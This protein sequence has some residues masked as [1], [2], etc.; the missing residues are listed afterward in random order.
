MRVFRTLLIGSLAGE[1]ILYFI[2]SRNFLVTLTAL[3]VGCFVATL[4]NSIHRTQVGVSRLRPAEGLLASCL[5]LL[6]LVQFTR[7]SHDFPRLTL[8]MLEAEDNAAW[9]RI[10]ASAMFTDDKEVHFGMLYHV[11]LSALNG[12]QVLVS[13]VV[14]MNTSTIATPVNSVNALYLLLLIAFPWLAFLAASPVLSSTRSNLLRIAALTF[15]NVIV[16]GALSEAYRIG[17]LSAALTIFCTSIAIIS[18]FAQDATSRS[19]IARATILICSALMLW[20]PLRPAAVAL[21]LTLALRN[22]VGSEFQ[23]PRVKVQLEA[24]RWKACAPNAVI[25]LSII[26]V[27]AS[28]IFTGIF[29]ILAGIVRD[30]PLVG[31]L[32]LWQSTRSSYLDQLLSAPGGTVFIGELLVIE[33][34]GVTALVSARAAFAAQRYKS[35]GVLGLVL[36]G[37]LTIVLVLDALDDGVRSYG[38]LKMTWIYAP[39]LVCL[40]LSWT[41]LPIFRTRN[42]V[43]NRSAFLAFMIIV[44]GTFALEDPNRLYLHLASPEVKEVR[45]QVDLTHPISSGDT[46]WDRST[47]VEELHPDMRTLACVQLSQRYEV[48]QEFEAYSCS[49]RIYSVTL[50]ARSPD[51]KISTAFM[52]RALGRLSHSE[53]MAMLAENA[54]ASSLSKNLI[55]LDED[56]SFSKIISLSTFLSETAD[57]S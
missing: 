31:N 9:L 41:Q 55:I 38:A 46:K 51:E 7:T 28:T 2:P 39:L 17:H 1:A 6:T 10:A 24:F 48:K 36:T 34:V 15:M 30:L 22:L 42:G 16:L 23:S 47:K 43:G 32:N 53:M 19:E 8:S 20:H 14:G 13:Y 11:L 57:F 37:Y 50:T 5:N 40:V 44:A 49:R 35:H 12:A 4:Q 18:F 52:W 3:A 29:G 33:L 54:E 25:W 26:V 21:L 56:Y 45:T 27:G